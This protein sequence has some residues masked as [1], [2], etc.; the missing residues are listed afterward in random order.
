LKHSIFPK[1]PPG[2]SSPT[3][4]PPGGEYTTLCKLLTAYW[5]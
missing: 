1:C 5:Y 2:S 3:G 4:E